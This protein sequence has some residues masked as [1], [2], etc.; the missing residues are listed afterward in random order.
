MWRYT[1]EGRVIWG[2]TARILHDFLTLARQARDDTSAP[3]NHPG[4]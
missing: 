3:K 2:V 1:W 4:P